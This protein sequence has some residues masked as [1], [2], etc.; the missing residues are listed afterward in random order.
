MTKTF[1]NNNINTIFPALPRTYLQKHIMQVKREWQQRWDKVLTLKNSFVPYVSKNKDEVYKEFAVLNQFRQRLWYEDPEANP[2]ITTED[3]LPAQTLLEK[4]LYRRSSNI[5]FEYN[6]TNPYYNASTILFQD[7][8]FIALQE[9]SV[10]TL[11]QFFTLLINNHVSAL[12]RVKSEKEVLGIDS[13]NYWKDRISGQS[14][15]ATLKVTI[16]EG[17]HAVS[18]IPLPYFYTNEWVDD[19]ALEPASLYQ[20]VNHVRK[21]YK[22]ILKKG[23]IACHCASGVGRTGTF[24]AAFIIAKHIESFPKSPFSIEE[25][26]LKLSI[27][28]PN[29][30]ATKEQYYSLYQFADYYLLKFYSNN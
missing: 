27:Q 28:R 15:Y 19:N 25:I 21:A 11:D 12:V 9:P 3:Y 30:V 13:I 2:R 4:G 24:I 16:K 17:H 8:H 14:P 26:V 20:L 7:H 18:P 29:F 22:E 5:A 10:E 1:L 23:P 6:K